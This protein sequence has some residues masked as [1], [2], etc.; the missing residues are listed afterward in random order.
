[1]D[2]LLKKGR[3]YCMYSW[4]DLR[5]FVNET[6]VQVTHQVGG[7]VLQPGEYMQAAR[8]RGDVALKI[9]V[10]GHRHDETC[11]FY[12]TQP[13]IC[14]GIAEY[15]KQAPVGGTEDMAIYIKEYFNILCGHMISKINRET[16]SSMRFGIPSYYEDIAV[17][18]DDRSL[19]E[20]RY[21][22]VNNDGVMSIVGINELLDRNVIE[23]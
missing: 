7:I 13:H 11:I 20:I 1:V 10:A 2:L 22:C 19:M 9:S 5:E 16:K 17:I 15:M 14:R 21:A 23:E 4:E 12:R 18:P 6:M 3:G 8:P